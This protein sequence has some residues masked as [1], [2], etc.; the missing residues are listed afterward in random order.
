[1]R[2]RIVWTEPACPAMKVR[3]PLDGPGEF[4]SNLWREAATTVAG[5]HHPTGHRSGLEPQ[6]P[7]AVD[8]HWGRR[9]GWRRGGA[10]CTCV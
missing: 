3:Q 6:P 4:V 8:D 7:G 1:M 9:G 2:F 5:T 10:P